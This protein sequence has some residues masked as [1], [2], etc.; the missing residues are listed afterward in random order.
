MAEPWGRRIQNYRRQYKGGENQMKL[1]N[2]L[3]TVCGMTAMTVLP[4]TSAAAMVRECPVSKPTAASYTWNFRREANQLFEH[5]QTDAWRARDHAA[6]LASFANSPD[7]SWQSYAEQLTLEK[8]AINDMGKTVCRLETIRHSVAPWQRRSINRIAA[9]VT[10]MADNTQDAI[11]I[12]NHNRQ[13]L[14]RPSYQRYL[15]NLYTHACNLTQRVGNAVEY[16]KLG[17]E[18]RELH[19]NLSTG[20]SS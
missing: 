4:I 13:S 8:E 10:L 14:W 2:L 11:V 9:T 12:G 1:K 7:L 15:D 19:N 3:A 6:Q 17:P 20:T 18:Y 5:I 16:A